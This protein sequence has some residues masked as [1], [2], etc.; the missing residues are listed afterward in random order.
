MAPALRSL[1]IRRRATQPSDPVAAG[2]SVTVPVVTFMWSLWALHDQAAYRRTRWVA[3]A[4]GPIILATSFTGHAV[5][6]TGL[7]LA[8]IVAYK[9][10]DR[11]RVSPSPV[12]ARQ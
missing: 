11:R 6:A 2:L 1:S 9:Q 4:A 3:P 8:A 12:G 10:A 5:L 7:I